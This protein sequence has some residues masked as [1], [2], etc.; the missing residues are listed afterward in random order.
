V[1]T[2]CVTLF[3]TTFASPALSFIRVRLYF[4]LIIRVCTVLHVTFHQNVTI[5]SWIFRQKIFL[6]RIFC[7]VQWH[8]KMTTRFTYTFCLW[9]GASSGTCFINTCAI[10]SSLQILLAIQSFPLLFWVD[11]HIGLRDT[12]RASSNT[13]FYILQISPFD[14]TGCLIYHSECYTNRCRII[15]VLEKASLNKLRNIYIQ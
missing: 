13:P 8:S 9:Y 14:S 15:W 2:R 7:E 1:F 10:P 12:S 4:V 5:S 11:R 3:S 6:S